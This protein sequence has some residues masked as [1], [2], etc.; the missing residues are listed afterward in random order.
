MS[1]QANIYMYM[2]MRLV[3]HFFY[4]LT[5]THVPVII[6]QKCNKARCYAVFRGFAM[7]YCKGLPKSATYAI[8]VPITYDI[9]KNVVYKCW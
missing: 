4:H 1:Y 7:K 2:Y 8:I 5:G 3:G 9:N 6:Y